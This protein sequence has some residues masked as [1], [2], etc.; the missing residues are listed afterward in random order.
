GG[1]RGDTRR[2]AVGGAPP[3]PP[4]GGAPPPPA[5]APPPRPPP[6]PPRP[7]PPRPPPPPPRPPRATASV[8]SNAE[9]ATSHPAPIRSV[10]TISFARM[11]SS[12]VWGYLANFRTRIEVESGSTWSSTTLCIVFHSM[13]SLLV[14]LMMYVA[15]AGSPSPVTPLP[16]TSHSVPLAVQLDSP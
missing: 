14:G 11:T 10:A 7:P 9:K 12:L 16:R 3:P 13:R 6:P 2:A 4:P 8:T 5:G 1:G 15:A